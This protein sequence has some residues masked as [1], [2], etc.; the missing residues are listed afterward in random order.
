M[1]VTLSRVVFASAIVAAGSNE[2]WTPAFVILVVAF[3]IGIVDGELAR[4]L[5]A[6][7]A[8][9]EKLNRIATVFLTVCV[10]VAVAWGGL[11]SWWSLPLVI[12]LGFGVHRLLKPRLHGGYLAAYRIFMPLAN[13]A[14]VAML[15]WV[16]A[17][18]AFPEHYSKIWAIVCLCNIVLAAIV[19]WWR[20]ILWLLKAIRRGTRG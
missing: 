5:D 18:A 19:K 13:P 12:G 14:L 1:C 8:E 11:W 16:M 20:N 17:R 2:L 4:C 9:G 10:L 3:G 6:A 7:T 15:A